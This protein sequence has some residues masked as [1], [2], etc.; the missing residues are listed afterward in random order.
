MPIWSWMSVSCA[1]PIMSPNWRRLPA[2]TP[3]VAAYIA[4]DP[5]FPRFFNDLCGWLRPLL[6]RY[7]GEGKSYFTIAVGCTGGRHRSVYVADRLGEASAAFRVSASRSSIA[8]SARG[9]ARI[10]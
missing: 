4:A 6:P 10:V 5:D 2:T 9:D 8:T 3:K 1:T 7:E